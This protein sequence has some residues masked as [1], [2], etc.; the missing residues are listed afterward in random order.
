MSEIPCLPKT[1]EILLDEITPAGNTLLVHAI[2]AD[3]IDLVES[4]LK[5]GVNTEITGEHGATCFSYL[6][7]IEM[8]NLLM[9][10]NIDAEKYFVQQ[11]EKG[12]DLDKFY[13]VD[14]SRSYLDSFFDALIKKVY[15]SQW[16][17]RQYYST[18]PSN[19]EVFRC[20]RTSFVTIHSRFKDVFPLL[21]K[22]TQDA[23]YTQDELKKLREYREMANIAKADIILRR[24]SKVFESIQKT[25]ETKFFKLPKLS[26]ETEIRSNTSV[27]SSPSKVAFH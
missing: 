25:H 15:N 14:I 2:A 9:E 4:L 20:S 3:D 16:H 11:I 27:E 22:N 18:Q 1:V 24:I 5:L 19:I 6:K 17:H 12:I 23:P 21:N 10:Y 8:I 13:Y 7:S 26:K